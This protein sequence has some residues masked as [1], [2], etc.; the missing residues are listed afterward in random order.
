MSDEVNLEEFEALINIANL[1]D[2]FLSKVIEIYH[3]RLLNNESALQKLAL[4]GISP[5][6]VKSHQLGYCDRT[7]NKYVKPLEHAEGANFRGALRRNELTNE[8]GHEL[9]RGCIVEPIFENNALVAVCG[10]KLL[11]PSK[12][13]P[14][15]IQW[16]RDT[17]YRYPVYFYI[18][19]M[20]KHYVAH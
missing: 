1:D 16:Y 4:L 19:T 14:R 8:S 12:A 11:T 9:F 15:V 6:N 20:A 10:V 3:Q 2:V 17:V 18:M 7:L 13:A 5:E